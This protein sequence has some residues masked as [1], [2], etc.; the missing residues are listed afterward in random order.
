[1]VGQVIGL[2]GR[3]RAGKDEVASH[4]AREHGYTVIGM[5]DA[6]HEAMLALDP[7]V[8]VGPLYGDIEFERYSDVVA[9][10]G[11]VEAKKR[12]EVR[13]LLQP[14]GTEVGRGLIG[15]NVW[16]DI[17]ARKIER[18]LAEGHSVALTGCRFENELRMIHSFAGRAV[19]VERPSLN[20]TPEG[21]HASEVSLGPQD[22]DLTVV[23]DGSLADLYARVDTLLG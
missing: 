1:M 15:E 13:R 23:N 4:L 9:Q 6:L 22:F 7:I 14:L 8:D 17:T 10:V 5:S 16:V 3:L 19:W 11:Y 20:P 12:P 21:V 2:G 18:L